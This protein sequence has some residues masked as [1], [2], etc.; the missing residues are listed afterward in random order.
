MYLLLALLVWFVARFLNWSVCVDCICG[1]AGR[2]VCFV[3][4]LLVGWWVGCGGV[5]ADWLCFVRVVAC[6]GWAT[7]GNSFCCVFV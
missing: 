1:V 2:C 7:F 5:T 3:L 6:V 4:S